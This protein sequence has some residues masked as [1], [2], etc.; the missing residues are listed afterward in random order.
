MGRVYSFKQNK[1]TDFDVVIGPVAD[2]KT[3]IEIKKF[4]HQHPDG[5]T[6]EDKQNLIQ[7]LEPWKFVD[8]YCFKTQKAVDLL[9]K[10]KVG[11]GK[12]Y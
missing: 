7:R 2:M 9:N 3:N 11:G 6:D 1:Y 5:G 10:Y 4:T 8:Q 12:E